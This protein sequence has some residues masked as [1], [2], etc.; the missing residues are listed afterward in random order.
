MGTGAVKLFVGFLVLVLVSFFFLSTAAVVFPL[1]FAVCMCSRVDCCGSRL[2]F[3]RG[4]CKI[5]AS[6]I[7]FPGGGAED[8][9]QV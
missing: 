3:F 2:I 9:G 7:K 6:K 4:V 8:I 5:S 1:S